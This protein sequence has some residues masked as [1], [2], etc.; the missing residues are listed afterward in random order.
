VLYRSV[1]NVDLWIGILAEDHLPNKSVGRTLNAMLKSQFEKLRDGDF[2][3]YLNDPYLSNAIRDQIKRTKFSDIIRRNTG[4]SNIAVNAFRTDSCEE[5]EGITI[6]AI[7]TEVV[8]KA[9]YKIYPNP[10]RDLLTID[11]TGLETPTS[12]KIVR[13]DGV[14]IKTIVPDGKQLLQVNTIGLTSGIYMVNI[15]NSK[16]TK[17]F[18]FVKL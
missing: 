16:E 14:L 18:S 13:S 17:S 12:I 7:T 9:V 1:N 4:L 15:T 2:Y 8:P 11:M 3:F 5:E 10:V 6:Q